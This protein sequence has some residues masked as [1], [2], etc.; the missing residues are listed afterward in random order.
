MCYKRQLLDRLLPE[1]RI[2]DQ[3]RLGSQE[4][5][6]DEFAIA[7]MCGL[8]PYLEM[9]FPRRRDFYARYFRL[10]D[11]SD[12]EL[13]LWKET[14]MTFLKKITLQDPRP[15][16]LKSPS[17]TARLS[18]LR[19]MF[20]E[21]RFI[22]IVRNPYDVYRS[23]WKLYD[24]YISVQHLQKVSRETVR[25]NMLENYRELFS[26]FEEDRKNVP[27]NRLALVKYEKL[28][29]DPIAE[30]RRIYRQLELG[31]EEDVFAGLS[32]YLESIKGYRPNPKTPLTTGDIRLVNT[33]CRQVFDTYG[34]EMEQG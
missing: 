5:Q 7:I 28:V 1:T 31:E 9:M 13:S 34:Y 19:T 23:M 20:P 32:G 11:I 4:P 3:V 14:F 15:V 17:H 30:F 18:L 8:S 33:Y 22:H 6:E 26:A 10:K 24:N 27:E 25:K 2:V 12:S 29:Q 21:A 16:V